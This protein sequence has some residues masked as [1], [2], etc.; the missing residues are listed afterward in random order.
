[1]SEVPRQANADEARVGCRGLEDQ[2]PGLVRAAV[3]HEHD[4]VGAAGELVEDGRDA[5]NELG[6]DLVLIVNRDRNRESA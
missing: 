6:E 1:V 5:A 4:L 2:L 3:V